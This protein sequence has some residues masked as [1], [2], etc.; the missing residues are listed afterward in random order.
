[1]KVKFFC[2]SCKGLRNHEIIFEH[3]VRGEEEDY[4]YQW[5]KKYNVIQC[6]GCDD[7][8]FLYVFGDNQMIRHISEDEI[9]YYEDEIIYPYFLEKGAEISAYHLPSP[10]KEI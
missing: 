2:N 5:I 3:K 8:S 4:A 1:M 9:D 7:I 10:I 6:S